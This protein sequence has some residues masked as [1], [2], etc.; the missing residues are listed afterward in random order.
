MND[1]EMREFL[2]TFIHEAAENYFPPEPLTHSKVC[3]S[4]EANTD[5]DQLV[6]Q[7][8]DDIVGLGPLESL[9]RDDEISEIM[10]NRFDRIFVEREGQLTRL[11]LSF[12]DEP[13]VRRI[14]ERIVT[15]IGR[16]I[17]DASPMVDARLACGSRVH[18]MIPPLAVDGAC[19]TI[20]KFSTQRLSLSDLVTKGSCSS[21]L[22]D[23]LEQIVAARLN[24][25]ICGGT[26]SGKTTLLNILGSCID[27]G[28]RLVTIEDAAELSLHHENLVRLEARP[29]NQDGHG[30]VPIRELVRNALRMRPDRIIVGECRAGEAFDMLQAMN[31]GHDGSMA[32]LHANS[33]RDGIRRLETLVLMAGMDL[34]LMAVRQQI[35][36]AVKVLVQVTRTCSGKRVISSLTEVQGMEGEIVLLSEIVR[37]NSVT[38]LHEVT[39]DMP[40]FI[41]RLPEQERQRCHQIFQAAL[42]G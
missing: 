37:W 5:I 10:V 26:G 13:S 23:L 9:L 31:T 39:G 29:A 25:M 18:A 35:A 14:I 7:V 32:T 33:P 12:N 21:A 28:E 2:R 36:S 15:P 17:D 16:R 40:R 27:S 4:H 34:P 11:K 3:S 42:C 22:S 41:D 38:Q 24:L 19:L 30:A 6:S 20:R 8:I 1:A